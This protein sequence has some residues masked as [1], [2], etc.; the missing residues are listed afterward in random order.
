MSKCVVFRFGDY[1]FCVDEQVIHD[2]IPTNGNGVYLEF[3]NEEEIDKLID[4][5]NKLKMKRGN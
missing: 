3:E 5:L 2:K 4:G 1:A